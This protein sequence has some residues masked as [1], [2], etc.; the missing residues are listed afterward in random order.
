MALFEGTPV[1]ALGME[2]IAVLVSGRDAIRNAA[3]IL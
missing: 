2:G 3:E 1:D